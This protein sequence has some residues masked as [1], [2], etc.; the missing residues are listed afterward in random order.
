MAI[1]VKKMIKYS[2]ILCFLLPV[3]LHAKDKKKRNPSQDENS[4]QVIPLDS[5]AEAVLRA[6]QYGPLIK[7]EGQNE[8][9]FRQKVLAVSQKIERFLPKGTDKIYFVYDCL[10]MMEQGL[11]LK[12]PKLSIQQINSICISIQKEFSN[13]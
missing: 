7:E 13:Q 3:S 4:Q 8:N 11:K 2:I 9:E 6:S 5:T 10:F 1:G 12:Y